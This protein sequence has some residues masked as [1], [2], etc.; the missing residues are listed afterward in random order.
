MTLLEAIIII[1]I[2]PIHFVGS[3]AVKVS[4]KCTTQV[5]NCIR[6]TICSIDVVR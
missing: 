4:E 2:N 1:I 6:F 5:R 3:E